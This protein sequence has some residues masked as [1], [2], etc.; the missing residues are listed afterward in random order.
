MKKIIFHFLLF[1][2]SVQLF[3]SENDE[4]PLLAVMDIEDKTGEFYNSVDGA[5]EYLR[6]ALIRSNKFFVVAESRQRAKMQELKEASYQ[7]CYDENCQ[8]KLGKELAADTILVTTINSLSDHYE[9][10]STLIDL[11]KGV[12]IKSALVTFEENE[13]LHSALKDISDQITGRKISG[14]EKID[15]YRANR[16]KKTDDYLRNSD[17]YGKNSF[18]GNQEAI[19]WGTFMSGA[20]LMIAGFATLAV[21]LWQDFKVKDSCFDGNEDEWYCWEYDY[22]NDPYGEYSGDSYYTSKAEAQSKA[23][24]AKRSHIIGGAV[25]LGAGIPFF[26]TGITYAVLDEYTKGER[27]AGFMISFG[28]LAAAGGGTMIGL[29]DGNNTMFYG[30]IAAA[31]VGGGLLIGGITMAVLDARARELKGSRPQT[32]FFVSPTK[33]GAYAQLG[34]NF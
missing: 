20:S 23:D 18:V 33:G 21:G 30:G 14:S 1:L 12:H 19:M 5:T 24:K 32:S 10:V 2:I 9:I 11:E 16:R 8:L 22:V 4:K 13:S 17:F 26:I 25:L 29:N 28:V 6:N 3:A 15:R 31:A 7:G 34:V 27:A